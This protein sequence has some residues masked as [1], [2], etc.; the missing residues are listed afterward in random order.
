[1]EDI[2]SYMGASGV[3]LSTLTQSFPTAEKDLSVTNT[4][5]L[6]SIEADP[7]FGTASVEQVPSGLAGVTKLVI[8]SIEADPSGLDAHTPGAKLD[9]GKLLPWLCLAG[10]ANAL[11]EVAK[12][13]TKGAEKYTPNGWTKVENGEQRYMEAFGRH[14]L[15]LGTGE[16]IDEDTQCYH[17]AQM[18][19]NL[20]ASLELHLR[21]KK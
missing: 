7:L 13:T 1:M 2:M 20:L 9:Q 10:F 5:N 18:C 16:V 15:K 17:K 14:L 11:T 6:R 12:V 21:S 4:V 3:E 8:R 19:W